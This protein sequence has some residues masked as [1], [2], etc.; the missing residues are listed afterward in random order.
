MIKAEELNF[1]KLGGLIPAVVVDFQTSQ[2]LMVGFMN[3]EAFA[4]TIETQRV[5]FFSRTKNALWTKGETSGNF[6]N[7]VDIKKDCDNDSLLIFAKPVG[8]TCHT[9]DYSCFGVEKSNINFLNRLSA[10]IK[11]RKKKLPENSYT[12]KLF[13]EGANRII[14][15]VGE[16][17]IETVIA[18]KNRDK[19]E[20]VNE[21]ADLIYHLLVML[22]EQNIELEDVVNKLVE[23]HSGK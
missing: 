19:N 5:T 11:E 16:E 7:L 8:P 9:G 21:T 10:L 1:E 23:R 12:T 17:A 2:V 4:K 14:Q 3:N 6:L 22:A 18:A 15:K 13:K 20:I